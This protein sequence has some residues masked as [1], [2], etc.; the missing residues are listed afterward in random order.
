VTQRD[1]KRGPKQ[2]FEWLDDDGLTT[3]EIAAT[4][5][6]DEIGHIFLTMEQ[7]PAEWDEGDKSLPSIRVSVD[8]DGTNATKVRDALDAAIAWGREYL[9]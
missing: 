4:I 5:D 9:S 3:V 6:V 2:V 1:V 7:R 8:I